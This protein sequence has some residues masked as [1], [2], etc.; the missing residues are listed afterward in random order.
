MAPLCP[1]LCLVCQGE[2]AP[3]N[4]RHSPKGP[5]TLK[6]HRKPQDF[7]RIHSAHLL[8]YHRTHVHTTCVF[9]VPLPLTTMALR[10]ILLPFRWPLL[11]YL[12]LFLVCCHCSQLHKYRN[13]PG[14]ILSHGLLLCCILYFRDLK[15]SRDL[16]HLTWAGASQICVSGPNYCSWCWHIFQWLNIFTGHISS[17]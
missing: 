14:F 11:F 2:L 9:Q 4:W 15:L 17:I 5:R 13:F 1:L 12:L 10:Y 6:G 8:F 16:N 3:S 7:L